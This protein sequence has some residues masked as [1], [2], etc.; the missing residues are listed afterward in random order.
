[1]DIGYKMH[2][3]KINN[4]FDGVSECKQTK[5]MALEREDLVL[6][7]LFLQNK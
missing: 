2:I 4:K 3:E 6:M 7:T 1:V 5:R